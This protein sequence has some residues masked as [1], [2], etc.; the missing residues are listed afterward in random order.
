MKLRRQN[1]LLSLKRRLAGVVVCLGLVNGLGAAT[2]EERFAQLEKRLAVVEAENGVLRRQIGT[3]ES[4][5]VTA[6]GREKKLS[7]G[8]FVHA[9]FESGEAPD[10]RFAGINDR[11]LLR[12]ARVYAAAAFLE[13][14]AFKIEADFGN[15]SIAPRTA[16]SGQI[17]DAFVAWTQFP[18]ASL[19][20]GQFKTPFGFEQLTSD[21]KTITAERG[22]ANDRLTLG[23]QI[24][25]ALYGELAEK[26]FSYSLSAF[27][28]AGTNNGGNDN[29]HFL[30]VGRV[31]ATAWDGRLAGAKSKVSVGTNAFTT[32]DKGTFVG[33]RN[34]WGVD[35]QVVVGPAE[36]QAEW[37]QNDF[38]PAVGLPTTAE[39]WSLL[40]TLFILPNVQGVLRYERFDSNTAA[41]R[42]TT[43]LWTLGFNYFFKG[44]DLKLSLNYLIGS[45]PA[46]AQDGGRLLGRFQVVF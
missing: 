7:V 45:Q 6:G 31:A 12:R 18:A 42:T 32:E 37:L 39:G 35:S 2:L 36:L 38:R 34:G 25:G 9:H 44:D 5:L 26:R 27:N 40:G 20:L 21:T 24:G 17:T 41:P 4:A 13:D 10:A 33:R 46:G 30:W 28:G 11:F 8:G 1:L 15:N 16:L 43:E 19:R 22:L 23:R 3:A 14:V 29:S